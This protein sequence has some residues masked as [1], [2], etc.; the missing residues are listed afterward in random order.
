MI[1][2][3]FQSA[4]V[5]LRNSEPVYP[6]IP[7]QFAYKAETSEGSHSQDE[8]SDANGRRQ[9]SYSIS[10]ADGRQ[11]SVSYVADED[12][13]RAEVST[14]ELGTESKDA[15]DAKYSSSAITGKEA[16]IQYGTI[17]SADQKVK[18]VQAPGPALKIAA[19]APA[20][21]KTVQAAPVIKTY[22]HAAPSIVKTIQTAPVIKTYTQSAPII[23][24]YTQ[25]APII[26]AY[27]HAAPTVVKTIQ[28]APISYAVAHTPVSYAPSHA[29][30][31]GPSFIQFKYGDHANHE[32]HL[33]ELHQKA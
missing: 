15:A 26:K 12:G 4:Q 13:F 2:C 24:T 6:P 33:H 10:L 11:R 18:I 14:N 25:S 16:A 21:I 19:P 22:T 30:P 5:L 23:R 28:A 20:I 29:A 17:A 3:A 9:G 32:I 27:A 31:A 7:Y 1:V 8:T